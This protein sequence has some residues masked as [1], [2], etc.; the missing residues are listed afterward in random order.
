MKHVYI[1]YGG[2]DTCAG[3]NYLYGQLAATQN[4]SIDCVCLAPLVFFRVVE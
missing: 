4:G 1:Q 2:I 3:R